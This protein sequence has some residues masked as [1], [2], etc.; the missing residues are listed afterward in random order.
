MI[1]K[2]HEVVTFF[3]SFILEEFVGD[4]PR[5]G[6]FVHIT[7][8]I[9]FSSVTHYVRLKIIFTF[10]YLNAQNTMKFK[11]LHKHD[12]IFYFWYRVNKSFYGKTYEREFTVASVI[13]SRPVSM[14]ARAD[15]GIHG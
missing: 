12:R 7:L 1:V 4:T 11:S 15:H 5:T 9:T 2:P 8:T 10:F 3:F 14:E 6:G 13:S